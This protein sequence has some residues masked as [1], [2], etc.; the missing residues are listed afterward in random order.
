MMK[1]I[2]T[3]LAAVLLFGA[4]SAHAQ[5]FEGLNVRTYEFSGVRPSGLRAVVGTVAFE[6]DN[7]GDRRE[8]RK[9]RAT[10]YKK[11][12]PFLLAA[13][14]DL[15]FERGLGSYV[16]DGKVKLARNVNLFE[17]VSSFLHFDPDLYVVSLS[18]HLT[19]EDG[20]TS[21]V[22]REELPVSHFLPGE[23]KAA[24]P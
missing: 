2:L 22:T 18:I 1:R 13:C 10:V 24:E 5:E 8:L 9:I 17:A 21:V 19:R 15:V 6:L 12:K 14:E 7:S 4:L 23:P 11:G 3:L 20:T 16:A